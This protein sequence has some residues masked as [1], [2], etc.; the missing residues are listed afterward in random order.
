MN[1][2]VPCMS[3]NKDKTPL[4]EM[5]NISK[6][7]PGV[8]ALRN[9]QLTV[10]PGEIHSLM[11]ENGA[12]K[13]TL[14]KV[15]SGA[16]QA[17]V[18][19]E[20]RI[21]GHSVTINNPVDAKHHGIAVIYQELSLS[22]NLTVA[23]NIYMGR[24]L[25]NGIMIDRRSMELG[26]VDVLEKLGASFGPPTRVADLSIAE[27]QLVEIARAIHANARILVMDEPTTAL[28]SRET[29]M[30]FALIKKLKNEGL[31]I[32]Y[33]SHRMNE[34]YELSDRVSVMR[35]GAYVGQ[36]SREELSSERLVKMMVGRDISGFYTKDHDA[37]GSRGK[38]LFE[39][40]RLR[41]DKAVKECD[42]VLH[43]GEV[44]CI[45]GLVGSGRT[46]LARLIFGADQKT[47][48]KILI[49]GHEVSIRSPRQALNAGIVY[50]TEDRK[51]QGVFLDMSV[52]DNLNLI[53]CSRDARKGGILDRT[54]AEKR[55]RSAITNL[56][57]RVA[58]PRS[59]V[60]KLSGGNQQKVLLSRLLE[61]DPKVL[62]LDEPT[63]GVDVGAKSEIYKIIDELVASGIGIIVISSE[64]PEVVGIADRVLIMRDG[65]IGGEVGGL[66]GIA[67]TQENIM[68]FATGANVEAEESRI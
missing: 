63:R 21:D 56:A 2:E 48:G 39:A 19:G 27:R 25:K 14:M 20:I 60:G 33:I 7:F 40:R 68:H 46:E 50:L 10:Y 18:G 26:C 9:V 47:G 38:V 65:I 59:E 4:L 23:E 16:Y 12:G 64:L 57:I 67:I 22:P 45:A 58:S 15:L 62:I 42:F 41:D 3:E 54:K 24:E 32:I 8:K 35:D 51:A 28:S 11:G 13:S 5:C 31:A 17:D 61:I 37:K 66:S 52:H 1:T 55:S 43:Q 30:M 44:L 34:I 29:D 53:V 6:T 36:L 49:E